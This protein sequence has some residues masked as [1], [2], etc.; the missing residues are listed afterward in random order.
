LNRRLRAENRIREVLIAMRQTTSVVRFVPDIHSFHLL[1]HSVSEVA[2]L[3]VLTLT[4]S[5]HTGLDST[6]KALEEEAQFAEWVDAPF[7]LARYELRGP[8]RLV[9]DRPTIL[10]M[11]AFRRAATRVVE[12]TDMLLL[13]LIA[14]TAG[15]TGPLR[16]VVGMAGPGAQEA[17]NLVLLKSRYPEYEP[18]IETYLTGPRYQAEGL[19]TAFLRDNDGRLDVVFDFST[20]EAGH[21]GTSEVGKEI[22]KRAGSRWASFNVYV[23]AP[24]DVSRFHGLDTIEGVRPI[25]VDPDRAF[26]AAIRMAQ[27]FVTSTRASSPAAWCSPPPRW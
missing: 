4:D 21:S 3:P 12:L 20:L 19:L 11:L 24:P 15:K 18:S 10:E 9:S 23:M 26:A 16:F 8:N 1:H 27:P 22:L 13:S 25:P 5:P 17:R 2:G 7:T 14:A 6:L